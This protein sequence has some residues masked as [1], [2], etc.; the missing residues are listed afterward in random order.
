MQEEGDALLCKVYSHS[1]I[2]DK[3][4]DGA[5]RYILGRLT[6]VCMG[7]WRQQFP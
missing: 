7:I 5:T 2:R 1:S 4:K 6:C 3:Q